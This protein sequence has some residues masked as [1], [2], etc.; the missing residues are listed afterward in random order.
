[1][2]KLQDKTYK[3]ILLI[4]LL[5]C[6]LFPSV[7]SGFWIR[8]L[9]SIFLYAILAQG[10]NIIAGFTGYAAF[11]NMIFFGLGAYTVGI[12][13]VKVGISFFPSLIAAGAV[14]IIVA[15]L[16]GMPLLRL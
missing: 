1:M 12:L 8:L 6:A 16:I 2:V 7:V 14:G 5:A 13:M 10:L 15:I 3:I 11:G 4:A 9:T